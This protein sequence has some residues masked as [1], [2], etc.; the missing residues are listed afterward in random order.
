LSMCRHPKRN[1]LMSHLQSTLLLA[2]LLGLIDANPAAAWSGGGTL[3]L[4]SEAASNKLQVTIGA[5][6]ASDSETTTVTG[7]LE[8][9][10]D[11]DPLTGASTAFTISGGNIAMSNMHFVL[12]VLIFIT[13]A[14]I[15]TANM[16]GSVYTPP[17]LPAPVTPSASGGSFDA[18]LHHLLINRGTLTGTASIT[19]PPT[20]INQ[21][22]AD[23]PVDGAGTGTGTITL[24]PGSASATHRTCQ[25]TL[26]LPVNFTDTQDMSGVAVTVRVTGTVKAVGPLLIPLNGWVEWTQ[27]NNLGGA[28]FDSVALV[29]AAPLGLAWAS[30][31]TPTSPASALVPL[32][33]A[34][35]SGPS[36]LL[37]LPATGTR[38]NL[39]IERSTSLAT[40]SWSAVP[41]ADVSTR[42]N[43]L[44]AN[45]RGT[46]GIALQSGSSQCFIRL[47]ANPP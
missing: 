15:S 10:V 25:A 43:P 46:V 39:W 23:S 8:A 29:G 17:P 19:N 16:G 26:V 27:Q 13:V 44:P 42:V 31:L 9:L 3:S 22:F 6:G 20:P 7:T 34:G 30:G 24:V 12:K 11:A 41:A 4:V 47:R 2:S 33:V 18:A 1:S 37:N 14:D 21:N 35:A 38:A 32:V 5:S 36:A 28:G 40:G 45:T